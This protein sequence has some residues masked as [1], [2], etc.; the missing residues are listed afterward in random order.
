[1]LERHIDNY[2]FVANAKNGVTIRW[3]KTFPKIQR[4]LLFLNWLI[5]QFQIIVRRDV[6]FVIEKV[7][8]IMSL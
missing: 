5:Y 8:Q 3:G 7:S 2:H 6:D 4:G 1:M